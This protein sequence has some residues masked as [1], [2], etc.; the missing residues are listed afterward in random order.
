MTSFVS[1]PPA[2]ALAATV[3][4]LPEG[5]AVAWVGELGGKP[6]IRFTDGAYHDIGLDGQ[7]IRLTPRTPPIDVQ[8]SGDQ[9]AMP[10]EIVSFG[11]NN[12]RA[13]WFCL[14]T[15]RY[16]HGVLGDAVEAGGLALRLENGRAEIL[17]LPNDAVFE[18]RIPR[19]VDID[20]DGVD[21]ILAV[22]SYLLAGAALAVIEV[23][24]RG[25][26]M[27]AESEP[28]GTPFR[29]L[30]PIGVA[31][32]DGDGTPDIICPDGARR[33]LR[34]VT[35]RGGKMRELARIENSAQI[36]LAVIARDL[37][38]DGPPEVIMAP[39][40]MLKVVKFAK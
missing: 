3:F 36:N 14:P 13:A 9:D 1:A 31:D 27:A 33:D 23:W 2:A 4:T 16:A 29:W 24:D 30:N 17:T 15:K 25:L 11:D 34:V 22:K 28:I 8:S 7:G 12:I 35:M 19:I 10:D 37:D 5:G 6:V 40:G 38:G 18:D 26:R 20:G 39:G 32:F 21:E